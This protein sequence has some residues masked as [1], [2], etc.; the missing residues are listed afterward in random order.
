MRPA[1]CR[2]NRHFIT[3]LKTWRLYADFPIRLCNALINNFF[4][5]MANRGKPLFNYT[6]VIY[7]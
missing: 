7:F 2:K 6:N 1:K 4:F 5:I 3:R